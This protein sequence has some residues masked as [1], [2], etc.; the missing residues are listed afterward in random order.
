VLLTSEKALPTDEIAMIYKQ[1]A[2]IELS[3]RLLGSFRDLAPRLHHR[4]D[5]IVARDLPLAILHVTH[6]HGSARIRRPKRPGYPHI[7]AERETAD[8]V[9]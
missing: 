9:P 7:A 2:R 6:I 1:L 4:D 5:R 8:A 3:F